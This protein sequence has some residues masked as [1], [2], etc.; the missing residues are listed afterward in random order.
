MIYIRRFITRK[1]LQA[2]MTEFHG[3][4]FNIANAYLDVYPA[5]WLQA[6]NIAGNVVEK[7][8]EKIANS[9]LR[10]QK[11]VTGTIKMVNSTFMVE[12]KITEKWINGRY[13]ILVENIE[14][15]DTAIVVEIAEDSVI[16]EYLLKYTEI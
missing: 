1:Q 2:F 16:L 5:G 11:C 14:D 7:E 8:N 9:D 15:Y 12:Y 4:Y 3:L 13:R 10:I 6:F